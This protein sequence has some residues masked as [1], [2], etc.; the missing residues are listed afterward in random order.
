MEMQILFAGNRSASILLREGLYE[1][2]KPW[3]LTLNGADAGETR[4]AVTPLYGLQPDT[5][6][7][8]TARAG[9]EAAEVRF[10][11]L[12]E[13]VTLDVRRFGAVGDGEH[14]DTAAIQAAITCCPAD[15]RVR[16]PKGVWKT[17]PLFLKSHIRL[18]LQR[19]AELRLIDDPSRFPVLPGLTETTDERD[20]YNL[21]SW[22]GNPLDAYAAFL[23]GVDAEDVIVYGEGVLDGCATKQNWWLNPK[24]KRSVFRPRTLFLNRCSDFVLQGVTIRNSPSWNLHPYFSERLK[25]LNITVL[26]P[27]DSPNTDGFDP[28]SCRDVLLAGTH[29]SLGDDCIAIKSGKIWMGARY[30]RP[31]E[32]IEISHCLMENGHGGVTVGSE[33]AGG[34]RD[35]AIHDCLMRNTD[36]GLRIKTRRG[37]GEQGVIDNILFENVRMERVRVPL[38]VNARYFCDPDGH[39]DYVQSREPQPVDAR[40]PALGRITF[41][42]VTADGA[43]CAGFVEGLPE[44][45]LQCLRLEHVRIACE[46]GAA[47]ITPIMA[48]QV[49]PMSEA[50]LHVLSAERVELEDV[51]ITGQRGEPVVWTEGPRRA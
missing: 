2:E 51:E 30:K 8:L 46:K 47:P 28:E 37:R 23:T 14:D 5:E 49:P 7:T 34:V 4:L 6:Y 24:A 44:K 32:R 9:E 45:P 35:V 20:E 17:G 36:R 26:A 40:T 39:S 16:V 22:E 29:F 38:A 21:G 43:A 3:R 27:A 12:P 50:G 10:R 25:F 31:S 48:E 33:M 42:H 19:G 41:R 15:G 13:S 11:T 1:T 18:E